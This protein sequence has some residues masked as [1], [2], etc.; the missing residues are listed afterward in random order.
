ML[1]SSTRISGGSGGG[2]GSGTVTSISAATG[3]TLTPNPITATGT[4]GLTIPVVIS[5]GGTNSVTALSGSSIMISNGTSIIQGSAGTTTTV[6]HGNASGSPTYSAVSL[7][8]DVSGILPVAN[9]GSG[10]STAFTQ[11]SVVFAGTSGVFSQDNPN[12]FYDAT[13]HR[14][15]IGTTAPSSLIDI[16]GAPMSNLGQIRVFDTTSATAGTG[17]GIVFSGYRNAQSSATDVGAAIKAAKSNSTALNF[18]FDLA[19]YTR[20]DPGA[21]AEVGRLTST[22]NFGIATTTPV[23]KLNVAA[24]PTATANFGTVSI[25][26]GAFNGSTSGF[27][28]GSSSGTSIA[29]NEVSGYAGDVINLQIAGVSEFKVSN[30]GKISIPSGSNKSTGTATLSSGTVTVSN[31]AIT[32]SSQILVTYNAP[33]GTLASGLSAPQASIVAGTSFVIN[34]LTTAGVVNTLDNSTVTWFFIN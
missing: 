7:T 27:F 11:G 13:N 33:S 29:V 12:F 8:A 28:V 21:P 34:S 18:S 4:V 2:G 25:G 24:S 19:F 30:V 9:G 31:T 26:T 6:L 1:F 14:L 20:L 3:I 15:G 22:G 23:S 10:T 5:S 17:G 16:I 32:A